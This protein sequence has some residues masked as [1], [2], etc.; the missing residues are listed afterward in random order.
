MDHVR[1][2]AQPSLEGPVLIL[3]FGGW[4]DAGE[5]ATAAVRYLEARWKPQ[6]LA[7]VELEPFFDFTTNRP[8][9]RFGDDGK[10]EVAW[11]EITLSTTTGPP[12][13][14]AVVTLLGDEPQLRWPAF[15]D[16]VVGLARQVGASRVISLGAMLADVPHARP[17][18][19]FSSG[20]EDEMMRRLNLMP[21]TYEGPT[22]ITGVLQVACREAGI[23]SASLWAAVP[24]YIPIAP[25]PKAAVALVHKV[26]GLLGMYMTTRE[27]DHA[28]TLYEQEVS[29]MVERD[30]ETAE[31]VRRLEQ[32]YDD[33]EPQLFTDGD[34][35]VEEVERFL[36][37]QD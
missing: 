4:N 9:V 20:V 25:S 1:W 34:S 18:T 35:L 2:E 21:S 6:R 26:T 11:P 3:A 19:I 29:S 31:Y 8:Q 15:V 24:S 12:E 17:V 32:S 14:P 22:G 37:N 30:D 33:N 13:A 23:P 27:L 36:R 7:T 10:R 28:A 5:A 16:V